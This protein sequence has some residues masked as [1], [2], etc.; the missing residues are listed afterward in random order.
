ML[1]VCLDFARW[2]PELCDGPHDGSDPPMLAI[3][4]LLVSVLLAANFAV[5]EIVGFL[6]ARYVL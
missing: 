5:A 2:F 3:Y 6:P 4:A 1:C